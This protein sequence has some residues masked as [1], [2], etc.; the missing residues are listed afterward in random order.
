MSTADIYEVERLEMDA[1]ESY[2]WMQQHPEPPCAT[3]KDCYNEKESA[4]CI[5]CAILDVTKPIS[6]WKHYK[7]VE[8]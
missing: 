6:H 3:C 2:A 8:Q 1:L 5:D 7:A 4:P